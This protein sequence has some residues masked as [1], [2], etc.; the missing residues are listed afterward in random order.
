MLPAELP[1]ELR[2]ELPAELL[3][4]SPP[5]APRGAPLGIFGKK[6]IFKPKSRVK[7]NARLGSLTAHLNHVLDCGNKI[8]KIFFF[9][10]SA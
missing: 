8:K 9:Q 7:I 4:R 10:I 6:N 1:A 2:A 3:L 5:A